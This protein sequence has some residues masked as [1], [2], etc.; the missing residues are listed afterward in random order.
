[1]IRREQQGR[2]ELRKAQRTAAAEIASER[3]SYRPPRRNACRERSWESAADDA[4]TV[5]LENRTWHLGK[6]L[7][8]FVINAQVLTA[9][10]W[11]TIEYVDC[12]HGS[13]HHHPQNG[14]DPRHI[15]RLDAIQD[16][17]EAFRLAQDLM[18]ERLRIIRR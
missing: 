5:R 3:G 8:E 12:C 9:E 1:M 7:T 6:H 2:Q 15:A 10:G 14:A 13:C 4:N 16:V 18:Y 17:T 11:R